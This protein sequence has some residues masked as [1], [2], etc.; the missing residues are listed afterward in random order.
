M[1]PAAIA[2]VIP[3]STNLPCREMLLRLAWARYV[4][5]PLPDPT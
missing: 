5:A 4:L 2:V 3:N 1:S